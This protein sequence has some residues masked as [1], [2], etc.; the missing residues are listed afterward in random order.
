M[1]RRTAA[2]ANG[3]KEQ[4]S[5]ADSFQVHRRSDL[6]VRRL[7]PSFPLADGG[8]S[9]AGELSAVASLVLTLM[10]MVVRLRL[11]AWL[12]L[13][14]SVVSVC[15]KK[16][17]RRE[18]SGAPAAAGGSSL[19]ENA[20][21]LLFSFVS[22]GMAYF[23][24]AAT[25]TDNAPVPLSL[26]PRLFFSF[27]FLLFSFPFFSD[28]SLTL[29]LL[30]QR[31]GISRR[32]SEPRYASGEKRSPAA[33]HEGECD[34]K[35]RPVYHLVLSPRDVQEEPLRPKRDG[36]HRLQVAALRSRFRSK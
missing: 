29:L 24:P 5:S 10:A 3:E 34:G 19:M 35:M 11:V 4:N 22:L 26:F 20:T 13:F 27:W 18:E 2:S 21:A 9:R 33:G 7:A 25:G 23:G 16:T 12:G 28:P 32:C 17:L 8:G 31:G 1:G 14:L 36:Q 15:D 30:A 6:L